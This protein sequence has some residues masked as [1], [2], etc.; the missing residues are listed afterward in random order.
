MPF[1]DSLDLI[2]NTPIVEVKCFDT[3]VSRLFLKLENQNPGGSIKDRVGLSMIEVAERQGKIKPG[4]TLIEATAGNTGLGL[5]L[6]AAKKGYKLLLVIPD[7]MS[8]EKIRHLKAMGVA[9]VMTRSD[10]E[11]GHPEYYQDL[12]KTIAAKTPNS[13]YIDQFNN[14]ANPLAHELSTGPE[15][16]QQMNHQ[17]DAIAVGVGS[18]GTLGGL[19]QFFKRAHSKLEIVLGDPEGSIL[20]N[21]VKDGSIGKAG[22]WFVEGIGEDFVPAMADFSLVK[23]AYSITDEESFNTCRTLLLHEGIL[24]GSSSGTLIAA[25]VR[26]AQAQKEPK[27]IVTFVCDSGNKYLSKIY[28]D[29]WLI[30]HGLVKTISLGDLRDLIAWKHEEHATVTVEPNDTLLTAY[31]RMKLYDVS[32]VPV[33]DGNRIVGILDESDILLAA[34]SANPEKAF[35]SLVSAYM[36]A[37]LETLPP[38]APLE[39]VISTLKKGLVVIVS[40][41][42][43]FY[44]LITRIDFLNHLRRKTEV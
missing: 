36:T 6:T 31:S 22:S 19:T 4:D 32:Q 7:K 11:K 3:G 29:R 24:A 5:A 27:R 43:K 18:G 23:A 2:G 21:Y 1:D 28:D 38:S 26:Y 37:D 33:L 17:V 34:T 16:W 42:E 40:D 41:A 25:A 20:T 35:Q 14:P 30:D 15:I 13:Y 10:V 9:I 44:G 39:S 12:A 8:R